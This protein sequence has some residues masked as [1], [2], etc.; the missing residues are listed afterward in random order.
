MKEKESNMETPTSTPAVSRPSAPQPTAPE[1]RLRPRKLPEG[2]W[3][4]VGVKPAPDCFTN[5]PQTSDFWLAA[6]CHPQLA[7]YE[8]PVWLAISD[9]RRDL[10][11]DFKV[12]IEV[13]ERGHQKHLPMRISAQAALGQLVDDPKGRKPV[14]PFPLEVMGRDGAAL[15]VMISG[16]HAIE[17]AMFLGLQPTNLNRVHIHS[18]VLTLYGDVELGVTTSWRGVPP[19]Q[20]T[21]TLPFA[22]FLARAPAALELISSALRGTGPTPS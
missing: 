16:D 14:Y 4:Q 22:D 10:H 21:F 2:A 7:S 3:N 12:E 20:H 5:D 13:H 15:G 9:L 11:G 18:V 17:V 8:H 1:R 19:Q 6:I